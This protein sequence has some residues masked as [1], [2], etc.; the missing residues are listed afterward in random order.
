VITLRPSDILIFSLTSQYPRQ[1]ISSIHDLLSIPL[2]TDNLENVSMSRFERIKPFTDHPMSYVSGY[3]LF[4]STLY[5]LQGYLRGMDSPHA[6]HGDGPYI[7]RD[8]HANDWSPASTGTLWGKALGHAH[9]WASQLMRMGS[10]REKLC[11]HKP[12]LVACRTPKA[13][14]RS[15]THAAV[16]DIMQFADG[17]VLAS[18]GRRGIQGYYVRV[19]ICTQRKR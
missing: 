14:L 9:T 15:H 2:D 13:S 19:G 17:Q 8:R 10:F 4:I 7:P 16:A 12:K 1:T 6:I 18:Q 3:C 11:T 5:L